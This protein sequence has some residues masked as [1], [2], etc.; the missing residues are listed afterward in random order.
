MAIVGHGSQARVSVLRESFPHKAPV[1]DSTLTPSA[2]PLYLKTSAQVS[3]PHRWAR[4]PDALYS[5]QPLPHHLPPLPSTVEEGQGCS[6]RD[7]MEKT[8]HNI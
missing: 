2:I 1:V 3:S 7:A 8:T 4:H 6:L 5:S